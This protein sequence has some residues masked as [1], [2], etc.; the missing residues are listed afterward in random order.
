MIGLAV[1]LAISLAVAPLVAEAQQANQVRRIG[2]LMNNAENDPLWFDAIGRQLAAEQPSVDKTT[3]A[4]QG[5]PRSPSQTASA[6]RFSLIVERPEPDYPPVDRLRRAHS[7]YS[8]PSGVTAQR[9][10][11]AEVPSTG[12]LC[13]PCALSRLH[14]GGWCSGKASTRLHRHAGS[15]PEVNQ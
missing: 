1:V 6:G 8:L 10:G 4:G 14:A 2:V 5:T 12:P 7:T 15:V 3:R 9:R 11:G 13:R